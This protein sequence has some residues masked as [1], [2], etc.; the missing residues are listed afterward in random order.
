MHLALVAQ[1]VA[2]VRGESAEELAAYTRENARA[3]FGV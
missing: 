1:R 3:L 2:A